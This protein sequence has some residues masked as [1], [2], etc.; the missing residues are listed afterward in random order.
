MYFKE[1]PGKKD[2]KHALT[3]AVEKGRI[4]HAQILLAKEGYGGLPMALAYASYIMCENKSN[5]D[6]CGECS[7][8]RKSHKRI[9]P[10]IHFSF[11]VVKLGDKKREITTSDDYLPKWRSIIETSPFMSKSDWLDH[12]GAD[13]RQANINVK[14]CNDIMQKL[15]MMSYESDKKILIMWLPEFLGNEGNRL[16][17]LIEEPT[18]NTYII[19]VTENQE[20]ILQTILSRC[21]LVKVPAFTSTE[22][23][24]FLIDQQEI[25]PSKANQMANLSEGNLHLALHLSN[26]ETNDYS[27]LLIQWLRVAYKS[28][29]LE[30]N[31]WVEK[32][33][34]L[35]KEEQKNFLDY[36]LHFF[37]QFNFRVQTGSNEVNL[38]PQE[39]DLVSKMSNIITIKKSESIAQLI[40]DGTEYISRNANMK[41]V[42]FADTIAIGEIMRTKS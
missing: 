3:H 22:I 16:L 27:E 17:K 8:C 42:L 1:I 37:R 12:I 24:E 41:I 18:D 2:L 23:S 9:H 7:H 33:V 4:P 34:S 10:D 35:P 14:E 38:T 40:N 32:L 15:N 39:I 20:H 21:Q 28:D 11:P 29:P 19:L 31:K 13:S 26:N 25:E 30:I 36:G 6:S 5:Q